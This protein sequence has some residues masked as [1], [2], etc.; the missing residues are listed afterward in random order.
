MPDFKR[1]LLRGVKDLF[2]R[3][4]SNGFVYL[5]PETTEEPHSTSLI[6]ERPMLGCFDFDT[7]DPRELPFRRGDIIYVTVNTAQGDNDVSPDRWL[8]A[9]DWRTGGTGVVPDTYLTDQPGESEAFDAF[10]FISRDEAEHRLLLPVFETG[11]YILRPSS[12]YGHLSLSVLVKQEGQCDVKHYHVMYDK[13]GEQYYLQED[14]NFKCLDELL[15]FYSD[16]KNCSNVVPLRRPCP[17]ISGNAEKFR[18]CVVSRNS[19]TLKSQLGRGS[20]GEVWLATYRGVDVAVKK[21]LTSTARREIVEEAATMY[22]LYHPRLVRFLGVC[23]EP[24]SEPILLITEFMPNGALEGYLRRHHPPYT[25]I[26]TM[27]SQVS[28]GMA[29]LERNR[30]VHNDLRSA[31]VL[32]AKDNSVKVADFG[33]AKILHS[34]DRDIRYGTYPL[35]WAAPEVTKSKYQFCIKAD[36]WS[37][38]VLMYEALTYGELPYADLDDDILIEEIENGRRLCNPR[39]LNYECEDSI[40]NKMLECWNSEPDKRPSFEDLHAFLES[41]TNKG[42]AK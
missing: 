11:T 13:V 9:R 23:C 14:E 12:G 29:Y 19:V 35:R 24:P 38:G 26:I 25:T 39:T 17:K 2:H 32:V 5:E 34:D 6:Q 21:A 20:F 30:A 18:G 37:F 4:K 28:E 41:E 27:L 36:I 3:S 40:Y 7:S 33:L 22:S 8:Q 42:F 16:E 1:K 31:N 10:Q 15:K